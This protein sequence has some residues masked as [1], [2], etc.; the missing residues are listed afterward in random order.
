MLLGKPNICRPANYRAI[1]RKVQALNRQL[2]EE[3]DNWS[4][5]ALKQKEEDT[6]ENCT[7]RKDWKHPFRKV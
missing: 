3:I 6:Y 1:G 4:C 5:G 2:K 7:D